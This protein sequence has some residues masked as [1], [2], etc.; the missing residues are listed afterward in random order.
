MTEFTVVTQA[1]VNLIIISETNEYG[2]EKRYPKDTLI[3]DLKCKLEMITGFSSGDMKLKLLTK[4]KKF[5]C[6][7]DDESKM[8]GFYPAED[9]Y[10][11]NVEASHSLITN[12]EDPNFKKFEISEQ[13]Y[14]QR[15]GTVREFKEK[16]RL[17]RFS[18]KHKEMKE[19]DEEEKKAKLDE[20]KK[21]SEAITVGSRC[22]VAAPG[23]PTRLGT[24]MYVG[25][26]DEKVGYWIGVKYDEPLGKNDGTV[27]G[28]KYFECPPKY[29]GFIKPEHIEVGDFPEELFDE[30]E[31]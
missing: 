13:E 26:M 15:K 30:D 10:F 5:V 25:E 12:P 1:Y 2:V 28:K 24:V 9:G 23:N 18:E 29:G 16:M 21:L 4:D 14:A 31:I 19:K 11:V 6:D 17:G 27:D 3:S 22:K 20:E 7:I 8:L